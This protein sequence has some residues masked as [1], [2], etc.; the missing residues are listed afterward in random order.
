MINQ[1]SKLSNFLD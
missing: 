1:S